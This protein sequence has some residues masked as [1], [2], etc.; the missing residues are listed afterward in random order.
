MIH[1]RER[2]PLGFEARDDLPG[3]HAELDDLEGHAAAHRFFLL[4]HINHTATAFTNLLKQFVTANP[5][6]GFFRES[7]SRGRSSADG[8]SR[9]WSGLSSWVVLG[10]WAG[11]QS[12]LQQ[13][14]QAMSAGRIGGQFRPAA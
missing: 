7:L 13:A 11:F 1:E 4:G 12:Q 6:T 5:V 9:F 8:S 14:F 10:S 2:L 3:I